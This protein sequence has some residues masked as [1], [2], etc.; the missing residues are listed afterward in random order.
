MRTTNHEK[1]INKINIKRETWAYKTK[2]NV[3]YRFIIR[4]KIKKVSINNL[5]S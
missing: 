1:E 5:Q 2:L 3:K 4:I